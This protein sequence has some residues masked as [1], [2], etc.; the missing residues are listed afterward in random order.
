MS[1]VVNPDLISDIKRYG[2]FDISACFNC[3]NCTAVCPLSETNGSF[4]RKLI[5]YGQ[6]GDEARIVA[7]PE[8]WLC[9]YCGEC[10]QTCPRQAEPGEYMAALR[11]Y[12]IAK[13]EPTGLAR[14]MYKSS[15]AATLVSLLL[16]IVFGTFFVSV[17][18]SQESVRRWSHW[19]FKL[20][21]YEM[22]H[23]MGVVV[24]SLLSVVLV[25]GVINM[26]RK[27]LRLNPKASPGSGEVRQLTAKRVVASAIRVVR[28]LATMRRH[29][30]CDTAT[31]TKQRWYLTPRWVHLAIMMGFVALFAATALDFL[32][33][34]LLPLGITTF[35][36]ARIIGTIGGLSM[37]YGVTVALI[38]RFGKVEKSYA[39]SKFS[40]WWLLAFLWVIG[41]TGFWLEAVVT[42]RHAAFVNDIVLLVH[43]AMAMELVMLLVFTKMAH[44]FY[45]PIALFV[46]ALR[47]EEG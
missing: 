29:A 15:L 3:G 32:F 36:P 16:A 27:V 43:V 31:T 44:V 18:A 21:P 5:R 23:I 1:T 11:R 40:D 8:M 37:M 39:N 10:S 9:Y 7:S 30:E 12:A 25:I 28:E 4:P 34:V 35:W 20:V 17:K 38:R 24:F 47:E 46:R 22:I 26:F 41:A 19:L 2:A 13:Y 14:L 6:I 33:V 45:R 42:L